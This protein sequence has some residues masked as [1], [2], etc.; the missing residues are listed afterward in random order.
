MS[1]PTLVGIGTSLAN[2]ALKLRI[3]FAK[4][5]VKNTVYSLFVGGETLAECESTIDSLGANNVKTILDYSVEG[6]KTEEGF[7]AT[8]EEMFR[9]VEIVKTA[10]YIPF[11]VIKLTGLGSFEVMKKVQAGKTLSVR[12]QKSYEALESRVFQICEKV[13]Q[14]DSKILIDG[15]ESWIQETID[16]ITYKMMAHFNKHRVVVYNTYQMYRHEMYNNLVEAH[17][18]AIDEGYQLGAKLVR[19]AYMEKERERAEEHNYTDPIQP[20]KAATDR[21][22]DAAIR[23]CLDNIT[24]ISTVVGSHNEKS[25]SLAAQ[26]MAEKGINKNDKRVYFAQLY[27]M[28][29]NISFTLASLGYNVT[30]YV[31]YGPVRKV[32]PYLSRRA[33]ENTSI[34]GQTGREF[35]LIKN[36]LKRRKTVK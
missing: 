25:S 32:M 6:E 31:P 21:D 16:A 27:G 5:I 20:D 4:T 17:R 8:K 3:P 11:C 34:A 30:K 22:F 36:E 26:L 35:N 33:D 9:I 1:N 19:G 18:K 13:D 23:F 29:D 24:T 7:E 12:E 14:I 28:S 15:E 10:Q 2:I